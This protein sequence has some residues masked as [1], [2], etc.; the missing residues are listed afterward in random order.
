MTMGINSAKGFWSLSEGKGEG[1]YCEEGR[2]ALGRTVLRTAL[3]DLLGWVSCVPRWCQPRQRCT[4]LHLRSPGEVVILFGVWR[5]KQS[6]VK[7][8]GIA[9]RAEAQ[10]LAVLM[11][12]KSSRSGRTEG[13]P[14]GTVVC[15]Q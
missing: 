14:R 2:P 9:W 4:F 13:A 11:R 1:E 6:P 5:L 7:R 8:A 12:S 10:G 3:K 15:N